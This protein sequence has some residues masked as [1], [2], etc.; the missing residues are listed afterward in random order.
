MPDKLPRHLTSFVDREAD[1]RSLK[2]LLRSSRL[3]TLVGTGGAGKSRLAAEVAR[4]TH[5]TWPDGVCWVELAPASDVAGAVVACLEL[6]G[7]GE[8]LQVVASWLAARRV[9]LILDNCEHLV[10]ESARFCQGVLDKC[11][12]VRIL[13]TSRE[14]L[15]VPGEVRWAVSSLHDPDAV[16]LFEARARLVVPEFKLDTA[17]RN[18]V[19]AICGRLDGLPLAI[20]MAAAR[21]DLMSEQELLANLNDRF[22]L[23][24]SGPRTAPERQ[25]TMAAAIDWSHR[26]LTSAE[27][28]LF[29]R[30]AV[31]Q[32]G[33]T[34]EAAVAVCSERGGRDVLGVLTG[35]VQ[36]SMVVA[37][38][39]PDSRRFRL[40]ESHH[41]YALDRLR[42]AG[43]DHPIH[44]RHFEYFRSQKWS[45]REAANFWAAVG[46]A[47]ENLDDGGLQ[48]ALEV[49]DAGFSETSRSRPLLLELAAR[50]SAAA[51]GRARALNLAAR[52]TMRQGDHGQARRLAD[53]SIG[54]ARKLHDPELLAEVLSGAGGVYHGANQPAAARRVYDEALTLLKESRDRRLAIEVQNQIAVVATELGQPQEALAMLDECLAFSRAAHDD[55]TTAKYLESL[56]SAEFGLGRVQEAAGHWSEALR[57]FRELDDPFGMIWSIGGLALAASKQGDKERA[58]RLA[59]VVDRMS[60]EWSLTA[61]SVRVGQLDE[62]SRNAR[63]LLG[64]RKADSSWSEGLALTTE[65][66]IKYALNEDRPE[67]LAENAGPLSRREREVVAMVAAGWTNKQIAAKLFIAERTAEGH[68]ERIRNKLGV[69]SRTEVATWALAHGIVPRNLDKP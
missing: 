26:L 53:E 30:L 12:E 47:K 63:T 14:P 19:S 16:N 13:A 59:A 54:V 2:A 49:A 23:L 50:P 1:L 36:K 4:A 38:R 58:I 64:A 15:G 69:R 29:R 44:R 34:I 51:P 24:A 25:Q 55:A 35:L 21:L 5:E 68:V 57:T 37:D 46:W 41:D 39:L 22:R 3:V 61:W 33:F 45:S 62:A 8:P 67:P 32:G 48:L 65:H 27:T 7:H 40:L 52:L 28:Q 66:A 17:N 60:R 11:P 43:E 31:F 20:E 10:A 6:P 42:E 56:A 9:L 18:P